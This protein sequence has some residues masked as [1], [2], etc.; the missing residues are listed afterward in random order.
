MARTQTFETA[1]GL[2]VK[3]FGVRSD[4]LSETTL[5]ETGFAVNF[6]VSNGQHFSFAKEDV[7]NDP[8]ILA[9]AAYGVDQRVKVATNMRQDSRTPEFIASKVADALASFEKDGWAVTRSSGTGI[10]KQS[11]LAQAYLSIEGNTQ[12][13]WDAL[14]VKEKQLIR[15]VD[16]RV[17]KAFYRLKSESIDA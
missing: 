15:S 6:Y 7:S 13:M 1:N 3:D 14:D 9:A 17:D 12:E 2:V 5:T 8:F 10:V 4:L 16:K 11:I